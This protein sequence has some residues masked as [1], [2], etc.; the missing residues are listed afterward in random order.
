MKRNHKIFIYLAVKFG[1]LTRLHKIMR[2]STVSDR[3]KTQAKTQGRQTTISFT[4]AN[5]KRNVG[6]LSKFSGFEQKGES[7]PKYC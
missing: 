3:V 6:L 4:F 5:T 2:G 7:Y 1:L